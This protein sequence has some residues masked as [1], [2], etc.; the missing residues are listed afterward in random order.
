MALE[1]I[2]FGVKD[3]KKSLAFYKKALAPL[4]L[5]VVAAGENWGFIGTHGKGE[6]WF[7]EFGTP[8]TPIHFAF[9]VD[10]KEAVD[11]FQKAALEAGGKD[12]GAPGYREQYHPG[13]YGAFVHD[14]DGHNVEAVFHDISRKS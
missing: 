14:P 1:H 9:S 10:N 6:L 7:G 5:E 2:G 4:G 13:Y 11:A 8:A 12:N 3:F